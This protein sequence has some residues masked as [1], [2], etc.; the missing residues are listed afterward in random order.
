M[1]K[2]LKYEFRKTWITKLILVGLTAVVEAAFLAG[3]F[4]RNSNGNTDELIGLTSVLLV[5]IAFGGV[6]LIGIQ[7]VI[8]LHRDMNTKQG[9]MLYMTPKTSFQIL[10]AKMA[11]NGLSLALAGSFFF[12]LGL[13]DVT[14]L[15]DRLG[16]LESLWN[17]FQE[18]MKMM[19]QQIELN[20]RGV[21][22][23][24]VEML[25]SWLATV[26]I[27]YLADIV[28]SALLNGKKLNGLIAFIFFIL[29]ASLLGWIQNSLT[30]GMAVSSA[31]LVQAAVALV[32]SAIMYVVSALIMDR[33][34]SV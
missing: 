21:L 11:E 17:Y 16:Q 1:G 20:V 31:L 6:V 15:F 19:N 12:L 26:S 33:Y 10:G 22:C 2:L 14:L 4:F 18:F 27:A 29:L 25:A 28:S 8:T 3:V 30:H 23:L 24:V 7:S 32:Y 9:Y 34:L 13:L 5:F